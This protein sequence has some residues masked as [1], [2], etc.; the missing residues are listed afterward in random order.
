M[1]HSSRGRV[2][3]R[4]FPS[5]SATCGRAPAVVIT[6]SHNPPHDNG[7]K[8][9]FER[10]RAGG[11]AARERDHREGECADGDASSLSQMRRCNQVLSGAKLDEAYMA[12]L[13][14]LVLDPA[15]V[16]GRKLALRI[17]FTPIHGTGGVIIKPM[18]ERLGFNFHVVPEQDRSR[19]PFPDREIA[20]SGKRRGAATGIE[21]AKKKGADLVIATDPGLR[22]DG[23]GGAQRGRAT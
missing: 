20:Q 14:T 17:V 23:R 2:R 6:A 16:R 8:V 19:R 22:P 3:R 10:R 4:S 5:P 15:L 11:G 18:L 13:E 21:L 12:R 1:P 9:Y 7:Y